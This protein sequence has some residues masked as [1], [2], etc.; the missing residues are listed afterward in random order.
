MPAPGPV[1]RSRD[2]DGSMRIDIGRIIEDTQ[3][4]GPGRRFAVWVQ[5]CPIRCP[6]CCNPEL[7]PARGG[8]SDDTVTLATRIVAQPEVEGLSL[9]GGEPFAQAAACADLAERVRQ[10]G[11]SVMV[12]SGYTRG[13]LE[14]RAATDDGVAALLAATD[15]LVDGRYDRTRPEPAGGRRWIGSANQVMHFLTDRYASDDAQL[16]GANSVEIRLDARAGTLTVNGWP[17]AA[18]GLRW[19]RT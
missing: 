16:R 14:E 6:G 5:G 1:V 17:A 15:L 2:Q 8:T 11:R 7:L 18:A 9:L 13:E 4:E 12:F 19:R 10:A 3:A